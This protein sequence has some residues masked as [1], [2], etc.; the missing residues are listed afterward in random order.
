[1]VSRVWSQ[2]WML[3]WWMAS[4]PTARPTPWMI[5]PSPTVRTTIPNP[6]LGLI[7]PPSVVS[8]CPVVLWDV[9]PNPCP[10]CPVHRVAQLSSPERRGKTY[11]QSGTYPFGRMVYAGTTARSSSR[12]GDVAGAGGG[13]GRADQPDASRTADQLRLRPGRNRHRRPV[14]RPAGQPA[15]VLPFIRLVLRR[16]GVVL[17]PERGPQVPGGQLPAS[18]ALCG[19][20]AQHLPLCVRGRG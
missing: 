17:E 8:D 15:R 13:G 2:R 11:I 18:L 12:T 14:R 20:R 3:Q 5:S 16:S 1:M 9:M 4:E 19:R 7:A 6:S 10:A